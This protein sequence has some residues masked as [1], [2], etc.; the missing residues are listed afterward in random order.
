M[1]KQIEKAN[2]N[3]MRLSSWKAKILVGLPVGLGLILGFVL[4][5]RTVFF[6]GPLRPTE[7]FQEERIVDIHCHSAGI[8]A[9]ESGCFVS[10][11]MRQS[12]KFRFYLKGFGVDLETLQ[13]NGD[14]VIIERIATQIRESN[15]VKAAI[16]LAMDGV[17]DEAGNL[18]K[19]ATEF[20]V[21]NEFVMNETA[22]YPELFWAASINPKRKDA[23]EILEWAH[24]NGAKMIKWLPSMQW[25]DPA[26]VSFLPFYERLAELKMPLISHAGREQ[27]FTNARDEFADPV[28]LKLAL[29]A[30][31]QV[32]VA[33]IASTGKHEGER[34]TDRLIEMM[35]RYPNLF[36]EISSLTQLNKLGY[37]EDALTHESFEGR[38]FYGSDFPLINTPL[39]SAW[40]FSMNL[41]MPEM[42]R[43]SAIQNAWDRD[44]ELKRALGVPNAIF[45]KASTL[46]FSD[47]DFAKIENHKD[48][49]D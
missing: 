31:V 45:T 20:F 11:E 37:L 39:V 29:D 19:S 2:G 41:K 35:T 47:E 13:S 6:K 42:R 4:I 21:P 46:L 33:H 44:V 14:A 24:E 1:K 32:I 28:K 16:V 23:I 15:H 26:D 17:I 3:I 25:F 38:L 34:D 5:C 43:L 18:D 7:R 36:S 27:A 12:F 30:G 40:F 8:G 48:Q 9:G 10:P 49:I 22:K